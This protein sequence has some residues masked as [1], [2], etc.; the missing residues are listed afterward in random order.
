M[1]PLTTITTSLFVAR[2]R[3]TDQMTAAAAAVQLVSEIHNNIE[4]IHNIIIHGF[5]FIENWIF[6]E[7]QIQSI[8]EMLQAK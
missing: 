4:N 1:Q 5:F 7:N 3:H 6:L 2:T 8:F